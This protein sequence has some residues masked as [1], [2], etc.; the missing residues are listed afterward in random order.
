MRVSRLMVVAVTVWCHR[1]LKVK[2]KRLIFSEMS[3]SR[4]SFHDI[5]DCGVE[6]HRF[7]DNVVFEEICCIV[8]ELNV[9][10]VEV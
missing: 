7:I 2:W 8:G 1:L 3:F 6:T 9:D 4:W 5:M 10:E